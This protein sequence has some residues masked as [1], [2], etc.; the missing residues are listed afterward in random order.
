MDVIM[1]WRDIFAKEGPAQAVDEFDIGLN[2]ISVYVLG[3]R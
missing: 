2:V 1:F 3:R